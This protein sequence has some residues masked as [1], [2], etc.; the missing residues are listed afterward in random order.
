MTPRAREIETL[1][2]AMF[3]AL[4]LY[5]THA[6]G[7]VPVVVFHL[8][9]AVVLLRVIAGKGPEL[10]PLRVLQRMAMAYVPFYLVDWI[11][12]SNSA[13]AAS[14]H[15][16]LFISA[17]QPAESLQR[18]NHPQRLLTAGLIFTASV[19]TSTHLT[20]VL[21]VAAFALLMFRQ[22]MYV[23]HMETVRSLELPYSE[24]PATRAAF[25]YLGAA[26]V[27]ATMLFPLLPRVRNPFVQGLTGPLAGSS[28]GL[29]ESID[30]RDPRTANPGDASVVARV[31]IDQSA[32]PFFVPLRLRGNVYDRF[33]D[34]EW[35][36]TH[37]V[38]RPVGS[39]G[40]R[41]TL[42]RASGVSRTIVVQQRPQARGKLFLPVGTYAVS[43]L[44]NLY[45]GP[46]RDTYQT[47]D[48]RMLTLDVSL[49]YRAEPLHLVR[50][51]MSGYAISPQIAALARQIVG[52][53]QRM[54]RRAELIEE[55]LSRN[56]RYVPNDATPVASM[57]V[58]EF[59]LRTRAGHCEYFAAGM[60]VLLNAVE[61]PA[62]IAGGFYGGRLNPLTGYYALRREDAHAWTEVWDGTR[63]MTFDAT[64]ASLRPGS[65]TASA[66][67]TY[68]S[69]IS[70]SVTYFWDR[71]VLTFGLSDQIALTTEVI[72]WTRQKAID[73]RS[74]L[75]ENIRQLVRPRSV[76][77]LFAVIA[78]AAGL[79]A[80]ARR[81]RSPFQLLA[82]FLAERGI[83]VGQ[84]MTLEEAL[85]RLD[86]ESARSV[87]PLV[88]L[89]E[90]E[91][92]SGRRDPRRMRAMKKRLVE[93]R[94]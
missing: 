53:E 37:R 92:F 44:S 1:L 54:E 32:R 78:A 58:D 11:G 8:F 20:I 94:G 40:G 25:F 91:R 59:L 74:V 76:M 52:G 14:T 67:R 22:L 81:P 13:V 31:W 61:V 72:S 41:F 18:N 30:F 34:G 75:M 73:A 50:A 93:L 5:F 21:F 85:S 27:I 84:A 42:G 24:P 89:Y 63:W 29:S 62:R 66:L 79:T 7:A 64:P 4:P 47:Y 36:Q 83:E 88:A 60:V 45:E 2:L 19:A 86:P 80:Y 43:G 33:H 46:S 87:A 71:Y 82:A 26:A 51:G 48:R 56:Y 77:L 65:E 70:D 49:A 28:T 23:S 90:E 10:V 15:L 9:M 6:I 55:Y 35:K 38:P 68:L 12:I 39:S 17:Y 57:S 69:A 16:V 3:A